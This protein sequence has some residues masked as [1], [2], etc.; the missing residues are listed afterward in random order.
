MIF[1]EII[2]ATFL[3]TLCVWIA[4]LLMFFKKETLDRITIFLV[5]LSAGAL[6]GGAFL[7]L[8][9]EASREMDIDKLCLLVLVAFIFFFLLEKLLFW[10]HC[11]KENCPIHTF[12]YMNLVGDSLHNFIDGL[13]IVSAFLIDYKLGFATTLA[14]ALHEIPQE[15]GDFGVLI[16][17]GFQKKKALIIN[18]IVALTVVLGGIVGYFIS[19]SLHN[20]I[21]YL[22]PFAAG[23]FIYIA[24]SDLMPEIRKEINLKKSMI[25]FLIF[26]LGIVLM[27]LVKLI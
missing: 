17:A 6:M 3:I 19:F 5:S 20:V 11:H 9:P 7:H 26:I 14:I 21:P 13:I 18:Y 24:A 22:L 23:G 16:H 10:R 12:G 25:S 8:L 27:F 1:L 2:I 15:I 4:V